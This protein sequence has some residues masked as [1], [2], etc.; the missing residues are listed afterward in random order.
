LIISAAQ[1]NEPAVE[2]DEDVGGKKIP[3]GAFTL[4]LLRT[5]NQVPPNTPVRD[6]FRITRTTLH[7]S[8]AGQEPVLAGINERL[9]QAL[10]G[11]L[12]GTSAK[13][14][15]YVQ[16]IDA[17]GRIML[18]GGYSLGLQPKAELRKAGTKENSGVR[19]RISAVRGLSSSVAEPV[20][21]RTP[22]EIKKLDAFEVDRWAFPDEAKLT[23]WLGSTNLPLSQVNTAAAEFGKLRSLGIQ[24]VTDP[25]DQAP[26]HIVR[27]NGKTWEIK[28]RAGM[29]A[30]GV[31]PS[32]EAVKAA[33]AQEPDARVFVYLPV[34]ADIRAKLALGAGS[35]NDAIALAD[36]PEAAKYWLVGRT[37]EAGVEYAWVLATVTAENGLGDS[38]LLP[39]SDWLAPGAS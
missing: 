15:L 20:D 21:R 12:A 22:P 23:V 26:T 36:R 30:L 3:H 2:D 11:D 1:Y 24:W 14:L 5:L 9:K 34:A 17:D 39:R 25:S 6:V 8:G 29:T 33:L 4:A 16:G 7:A 19:L 37:A 18:D 38:P 31:R 32:A 10:F 28:S 13:T 27:W 35:E